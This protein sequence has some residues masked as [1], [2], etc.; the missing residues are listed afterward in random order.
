MKNGMLLVFTLVVSQ[1]ALGSEALTTDEEEIRQVF[2]SLTEA[3]RNADGE[4]W[5]MHFVEDADFTVWFGLELKGRE[6][7]AAGHQYIFDGVYANTAF[8]LEV[9]QLRPIGTNVS[10]AHLRGYVVND[11]E[12]RPEEPDAVP[13]AVLQRVDDGWKLVTFHNTANIVE[14]LGESIPLETFKQL[15]ADATGGK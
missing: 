12:E 5:G 13:V 11:G 10:V 6:A 8:E 1:I 14:E 9:R 3:W 7:I 4:A 15:V 2:S